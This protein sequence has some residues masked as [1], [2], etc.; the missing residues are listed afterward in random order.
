MVKNIATQAK[1]EM[2]GFLE[3]IY[4]YSLPVLIPFFAL[5]WRLFFKS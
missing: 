1:V 4:K 2:P 3:Y 5:I